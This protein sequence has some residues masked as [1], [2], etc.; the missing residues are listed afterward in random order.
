M[1]QKQPVGLFGVL[2]K[3]TWK[4]V[5]SQVTW[6]SP[7]ALALCLLWDWVSSLSVLENPIQSYT[8][9]LIQE[10]FTRPYHALIMWSDHRWSWGLTGSGG[11]RGQKLPKESGGKGLRCKRRMTA[12]KPQEGI[13]VLWYGLWYPVSGMGVWTWT[14][15]PDSP[16]LKAQLS[17]LIASFMTLGRSLDPS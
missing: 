10:V 6:S 11:C 3:T 7:K 12:W 13:M 5:P 1:V 16:R 9:Y 17:C 15:Q 8:R 2:L 4:S 14:L